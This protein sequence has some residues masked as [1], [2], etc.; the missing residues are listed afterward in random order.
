V[1]LIT[2]AINEEK[3]VSFQYIDYTLH[4][5]KALRHKGNYYSVSPYALLWDDNHYYMIGYSDTREAINVYRVDRVNALSIKE[6]PAVPKPDD[7]DV[8]A[9]G[10]ESVN[11]FFGE[12][13]EVIL[14]CEADT[15]KSV[16]DQFGE[17]V[18]TWAID[19]TFLWT[20]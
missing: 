17:D 7:F 8:D 4:K 10:Q 1:D 2:D 9:Y 19:R 5:E 20:G 3:K 13:Q 16:I 14:Q 18:E 11:M 12:K 15:M 6:E